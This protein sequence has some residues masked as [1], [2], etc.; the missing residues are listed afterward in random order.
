MV[1]RVP[2]KN[3]DVEDPI[4]ADEIVDDRK[5]W[6]VED[7]YDAFVAGE[8]VDYSLIPAEIMPQMLE[9]M[10]DQSSEFTKIA[11]ARYPKKQKWIDQLM[12]SDAAVED[13]CGLSLSKAEADALY[14]YS[15][16]AMG[17]E[18][19]EMEIVQREPKKAP[20]P[21]DP[22]DK[23][24]IY[25]IR[26]MRA[27]IEET[28]TAGEGG[29]RE[30][31]RVRRIAEAALERGGLRRRTP[32]PPLSIIYGLREK[33]PNFGALWDVVERNIHLQLYAPEN[34][35][36]F[37]LEPLLLLGEPGVGKTRAVS[38]LADAIGGIYAEIAMSTATAGFV[39]SGMDG[40]W[41]TAKPG[42][43]FDTLINNDFADPIILIDEIDKGRGDIRFDSLSPL[44]SLLEP[45]SAKKFRDECVPVPIDTTLISWIATANRLDTIP[46]PILSRMTLI[47]IDRP[48][49]IQGESI[50]RSIY[51]DLLVAD[52]GVGFDQVLS[53][54]IAEKLAE[55]T[56]REMRLRLVK[57]LGNAAQDHRK[58]VSVA[59][60]EETGCGYETKKSNRIG[61]I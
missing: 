50:A 7:W 28:K 37:H 27:F 54:E 5:D 29:G 44:Y 43:I 33:F 2:K 12:A 46:D 1:K 58:N 16:L 61:F 47:R 42:R 14:D 53:D 49:R 26:A 34:K 3:T 4:V 41:S 59:D 15:W 21:V 25:D 52:W 56:P 55:Y 13:Y 51:A 30:S 48:D 40:G 10:I 35:R 6:T 22:I 18:L 31:G 60:I 11:E 38:A 32:C 24:P 36:H 19:E 39:L 57:G 17:G 23:F 9:Y 45:H 20:A 8:V